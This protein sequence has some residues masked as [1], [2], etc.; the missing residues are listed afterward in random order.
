MMKKQLRLLQVDIPL[1]KRTVLV[2]LIK[3]VGPEPEG[4]GIE[5]QWAWD[6]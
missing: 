1:V 2:I 5:V 3:Y 6:G 4:A